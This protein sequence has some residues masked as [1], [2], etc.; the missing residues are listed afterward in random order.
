MRG[1]GFC[2]GVV[3]A[4]VL[5]LAATGCGADAGLARQEAMAR[6]RTCASLEERH[7]NTP[8]TV[9]PWRLFLPKA[10]QR[11]DSQ[12]D[13]ADRQQENAGEIKADCQKALREAKSKP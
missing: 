10:A 1:A 11:S 8:V 13:K 5:G 4:A 9:P 2:T 3:L 6:A 7:A 12:H